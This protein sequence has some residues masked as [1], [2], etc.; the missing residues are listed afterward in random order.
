MV[1]HLGQIADP[2]RS[3]DYTL[4]G[5]G[6]YEIAIA[7]GWELTPS[8]FVYQL[9]KHSIGSSGTPNSLID[10]YSVI[11]AAVTLRNLDQDWSISA[12]CQ[13]CSD[14]EQ[15]T[16]FFVGLYLQDPRTWPVNF[17]KDFY[18]KPLYK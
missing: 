10:G 5:G 8:A 12:E 15:G 14:R 17:R 2:V 16:S 1:N 4:T 9:G 7:D 6:A 3:P 18:V 13:N 11:T